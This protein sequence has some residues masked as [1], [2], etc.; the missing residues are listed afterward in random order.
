[1]FAIY[2]AIVGALLAL[3]EDVSIAC[4]AGLAYMLFLGLSSVLCFYRS[5][6]IALGSSQPTMRIFMSLYMTAL[7]GGLVGAMFNEILYGSPIL[8]ASVKTILALGVVRRCARLC[9]WA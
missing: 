4:S 5:D 3:W 1:V 7:G 9:L 8:L 6:Y 2:F